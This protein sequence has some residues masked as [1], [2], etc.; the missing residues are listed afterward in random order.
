M[1]TAELRQLGNV[2]SMPRK[3]PLLHLRNN[4]SLSPPGTPNSLPTRK[5]RACA[6]C[7]PS[8]RLP[9]CTMIAVAR[10]K[11]P[12]PRNAHSA[13]HSGSAAT[14]LAHEILLR[15]SAGCLR[16]PPSRH[17]LGYVRAFA[18]PNTPW[19]QSLHFDVV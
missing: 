12:K 19:Q 7:A 6:A 8:P 11:A 9:A 16:R 1:Q 2:M 15:C 18:R 4:L 10:N 3:A 13:P 17:L 5:R 14:V